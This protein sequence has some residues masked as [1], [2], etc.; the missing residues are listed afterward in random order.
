MFRNGRLFF[1]HAALVDARFEEPGRSGT[2]WKTSQLFVIVKEGVEHLKRTDPRPGPFCDRCG[3][4]ILALAGVDWKL[5]FAVVPSVAQ[6][7]RYGP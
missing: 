3:E 6:L 7:S 5:S 4:R 1:P 2:A